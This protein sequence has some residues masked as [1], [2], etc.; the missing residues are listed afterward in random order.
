[1]GIFQ[2][3][4]VIVNYKFGWGS[5]ICRVFVNNIQYRFFDSVGYWVGVIV[6]KLMLIYNMGV[7]WC[8][9]YRVFVLLY[10]VKAD[11]LQFWIVYCSVNCR[12]V[13]C[14]LVNGVGKVY[15]NVV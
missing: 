3:R 2:W 4:Q 15:G 8:N 12:E 11:Y 10:F 6:F 13:N 7:L 9:G 14:Y 5:Y 1:M